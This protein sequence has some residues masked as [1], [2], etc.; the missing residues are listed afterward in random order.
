MI[1]T[2]LL[3]DLPATLTGLSAALCLTAAPMFRNRRMILLAQLAAGLC[4]SAHYVYLGIS[5]AAVANMLG[6]VQTATALL[7]ARSAA[8]TWLGYALIG[9]MALVGFYFWQGPISA[10]S[11]AAMI[12]IA[13]ARMQA[14]ELHLRVL[15]LAGGCFWVMHD[16]IGEAW[17]ALV[18]DIG[19]FTIGVA[20]LF[21]LLFRVTIEWRPMT[22]MAAI[23]RG[24]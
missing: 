4:F 5:V 13:L 14:N 11:M 9:L 7:S 22:A 6:S 15:L 8:M 20:I 24:G 1:A 2:A 19:A 23:G 16:Y 21:S 3:Q 17:I 10:L 12:L 18:A